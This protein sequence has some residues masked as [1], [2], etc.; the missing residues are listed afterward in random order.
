MN[1]IVAIVLRQIPWEKLAVGITD[2]IVD[3]Y[4]RGKIKKLPTEELLRSDADKQKILDEINR[5]IR[6]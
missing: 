5:R 2:R 1:P 6:G 3:R 4:Q